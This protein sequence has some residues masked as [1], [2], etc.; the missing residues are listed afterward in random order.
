MQRR[1]SIWFVFTVVLIDMIGFGLVMPV[2]PE[3]I[4]QLGRM[5]VDS[6]AVWAGW[7]GAG[8][9][10]M[11]FL[12]APVLGNLSDRF[13]RRPVLLASLF[14]F[15]C[16]YLLQGLA[17]SL[18]W[19][20]AGRV[21]AGLTGASFSAAYAYIADVTEPKDRAAAFGTMGMAFGFGFI[22]GPG[23]GG[24]LGE[25]GPRVPF[26]AAGSRGER[27]SRR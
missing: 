5:P 2:L 9:A 19:L 27:R 17:P 25:F 18:G 13:G 22:I 21:I 8:Y 1:A 3:L 23:L 20:V 15:G 14:A 12:C 26:L 11:Q 4:M 7:L 6:A 24:F 16:D 10:A